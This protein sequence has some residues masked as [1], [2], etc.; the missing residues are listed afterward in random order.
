M[1][2]YWVNHDYEIV[3]TTSNNITPEDYNDSQI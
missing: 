3:W 1:S 2:R